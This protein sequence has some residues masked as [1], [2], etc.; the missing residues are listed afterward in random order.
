V[1][2]PT[3]ATEQN[4]TA[5]SILTKARQLRDK[6]AAESTEASQ[7]LSQAL[8]DIVVYA[9][10]VDSAG[11]MLSLADSCIGQIRS[12]MRTNGIPI[13][14]PSVPSQDS[15]MVPNGLPDINGPAAQGDFHLTSAQPFTY[16]SSDTP[17]ETV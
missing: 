6:L 8:L 16:K 10:R 13:Q 14:I 1:F 7:K 2:S 9:E 5:N 4:V 3:N 12:R 15:G 17:V 11:R